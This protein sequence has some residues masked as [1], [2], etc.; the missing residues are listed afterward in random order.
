MEIPEFVRNPNGEKNAAYRI[1]SRVGDIS[2]GAASDVYERSKIPLQIVHNALSPSNIKAQAERLATS[3]EDSSAPVEVGIPVRSMNAGEFTGLGHWTPNSFRPAEQEVQVVEAP[4]PEMDRLKRRFGYSTSAS[5]EDSDPNSPRNIA[6]RNAFFQRGKSNDFGMQDFVPEPQ[7]KRVG[8]GVFVDEMGNE[9]SGD[10][11]GIMA[12]DGQNE[13]IARS[14][15]G[16]VDRAQRDDEI[17]QAQIQNALKEQAAYQRMAIEAQEAAMQEEFF[18]ANGIVPSPQAMAE[19]QKQ[20]G[21][22]TATAQFVEALSNLA[23]RKAQKYKQLLAGFENEPVL[24]PAIQRAK[25]QIDAEFD[26]QEQMIGMA[27][28]LQSGITNPSNM[29]PRDGSG[30]Q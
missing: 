14:N 9:P 10:Y 3:L 5:K 1:L 6:A 17:R 21:R 29:V 12:R 30:L 18:R 28:G 26:R 19:F 4:I 8:E 22:Q 25:D 20:L 11:L 15:Q 24:P 2:G 13:A 16:I 7:F 27:S 23:A